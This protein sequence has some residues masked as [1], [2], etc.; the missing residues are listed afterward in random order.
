MTFL[1]DS[2]ESAEVEEEMAELYFGALLSLN[3]HLECDEDNFVLRT[4]K[5]RTEARSLTE[6]LM[7]F[8]N[9][10]GLCTL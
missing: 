1:L 8:V 10:E 4:L 3:L 7:L 6:R 9:R 5:A 2:I